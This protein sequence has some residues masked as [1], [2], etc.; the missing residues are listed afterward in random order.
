MPNLAKLSLSGKITVR[1]KFCKLLLELL[2]LNSDQKDMGIN[3]FN[4]LTANGI[5]EA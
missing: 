3:P 2:D 1:K 5:G 4:A